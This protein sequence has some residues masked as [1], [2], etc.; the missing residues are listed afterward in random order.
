M[1]VRLVVECPEPRCPQGRLYDQRVPAPAGASLLDV[2][3]AAAAQGP[4]SFTYVIPG[5]G[6]PPGSLGVTPGVAMCPA[7]VP[8]AHPVPTAWL[9]GP[10]PHGPPVTHRF[11]T[12]DT[13][14]GPFLSRVLGLGPR[15]HERSYWQLL[16]A[17]STSL[18]MG[19]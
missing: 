15:R 11:D 7:P 18:Q 3:K 10:D 1:T 6:Y 19:E 5:W 8:W 2:L 4:H 9:P 12:Q 13:P 14:Q 16:T 17:P